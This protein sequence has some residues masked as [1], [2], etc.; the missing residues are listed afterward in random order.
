MG[1]I[2]ALHNRT[3]LFVKVLV[4]NGVIIVVGA[5]GGVAVVRFGLLGTTEQL[6]N[7]IALV[8]LG[9]AVSL[10]VNFYLLRLAFSPLFA[11]E[12]VLEAVRRGEFTAR[13]PVLTGDPD[14]QRLSETINMALDRLEEFRHSVSS[15]VLRAL[16]EER[17][18]IARELHDET[19]QALTS[20]II[21]I[22]MVEQNLPAE[23]PLRERVQFARDYSVRT[24]EEI[25]RLTYDL[26]PSILDDLGLV[27]ALRWYVKNR[28][29]AAAG[30]EASMEVDPALASAHIPEDTSVAVF[31]IVQEALTNVRKHAGAARVQVR[32]RLDSNRLKVQVEDDG[33]GIEV[34]HRFDRTADGRGLGLYGMMERAAL[35]GGEVRIRRGVRRGTV[36]EVDV[37]L[38]APEETNDG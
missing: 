22:E 1:W 21:N 23:H 12:R 18:R 26:R 7:T 2:L 25:R 19:S 29:L 24:L 20:I 9:L 37:P 3:R 8:V 36:V 28:F 33:R 4:A 14:V 30:P 13:S 6:W 34:E 35:V 31:R 15:R 38:P 11:L 27:P 16:E 32:L 5:V 17:K 10:L